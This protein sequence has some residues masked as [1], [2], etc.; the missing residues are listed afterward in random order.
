MQTDDA[1]YIAALAAKR[2]RW[3]KFLNFTLT[4]RSHRAATTIAELRVAF[5]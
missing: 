1:D 4:K 2:K 5:E 3:N